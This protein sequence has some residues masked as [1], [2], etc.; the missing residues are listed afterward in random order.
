MMDGD[1][2][3]SRTKPLGSGSFIQLNLT[4]A[5]NAVAWRSFRE[6]RKQSWYDL[7]ERGDTQGS[8]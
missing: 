3:G 4:P 6:I 2:D 1:D 5:I 7:R 8:A